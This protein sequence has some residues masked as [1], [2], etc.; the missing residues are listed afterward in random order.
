L[1]L[2]TG[3]DPQTAEVDLSDLSFETVS[4]SGDTATVHVNG[5]IMMSL[6]GAAMPQAIDANI[7]MVKEDGEW[8]YCG[9]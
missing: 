1:G 8:K 6:L 5:E 2:F 7:I 3:I 4:E 9:G